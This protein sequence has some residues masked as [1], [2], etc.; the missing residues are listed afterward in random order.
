MSQPRYRRHP[1]IR[2]TALEDEGVVLHLG[3]KRY[4]TVNET[5]LV[6]LE[7]LISPRSFAELVATLVEKYEVSEATAAETTKAFLDHCLAT[8]VVEETE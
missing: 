1:D 6:L 5:G 4:F 3:E 8:A 2:L 7:T